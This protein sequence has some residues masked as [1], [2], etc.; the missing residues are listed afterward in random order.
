M[1]FCDM[2]IQFYKIENLF[3]TKKG[4][5]QLINFPG[6]FYFAFSFQKNI[7]LVDT[8]L[9]IFN[10]YDCSEHFCL[11]T[12]AVFNGYLVLML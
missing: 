6:A 4:K 9:L 2:P 1:L 12:A 7:W 5:K 8:F 10:K 3:D 11:F